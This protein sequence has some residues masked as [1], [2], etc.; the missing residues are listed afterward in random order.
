MTML[1]NIFNK[2]IIY[3]NLYKK[4]TIF[5][6][7]VRHVLPRQDVCRSLI[8]KYLHIQMPDQNR[9]KV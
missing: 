4:I 2:I 7:K 5:P 8:A 1:N 3:R 9:K 6:Y